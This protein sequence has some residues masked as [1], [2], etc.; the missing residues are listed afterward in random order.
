MKMRIIPRVIIV[1]AIGI[2][3][4]N[5]LFAQ[6]TGHTKLVDKFYPV[7]KSSAEPGP[8]VNKTAIE[9]VNTAVDKP[10][11]SS[12]VTQSPQIDKVKNVSAPVPETPV[13]EGANTQVSGYQ[14]TRLGSST[15][16]NNTYKKNDNGAGS[17]TTNPNKTSGSDIS[18][19]STNSNTPSPIYRDT[20]LGSSSPLYNTYE[21]NDNGAG[22]ITTNPNKG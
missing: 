3:V 17:V 1:S 4:S 12:V 22:A 20:R 5:S 21:K 9:P 6:D 8:L 18:S 11:N 2:L 7:S 15:P 10:V 19:P 14:D 16:D 13:S